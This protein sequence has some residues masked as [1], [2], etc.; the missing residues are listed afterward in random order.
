[1]NARTKFG[2]VRG[3]G[4]LL[5][6]AGIV[7]FMMVSGP[8]DTVPVEQ[9]LP[10]AKGA[11]ADQTRL[12][13]SSSPLLADWMFGQAIVEFLGVGFGLGL[14]AFGLSRVAAHRTE[15]RRVLLR[16][17]LTSSRAAKPTVLVTVPRVADATAS[18][19]DDVK[20]P[21]FVPVTSLTEARVRLRR[22]HREA[23]RR[24]AAPTSA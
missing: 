5:G 18:E 14:L 4:G 21:S 7:V 16:E 2:L 1:M 23:Q 6:I 24:R 22:G 19:F 9:R 8:G 20:R 11:V 12:Q 13:P 10:V 3:I 15:S 17:R